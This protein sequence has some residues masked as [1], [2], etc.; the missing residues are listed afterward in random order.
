MN[1]IAI[2]VKNLSKHFG[3]VRAVDGIS[4]EINKAE[5]FGFLGPNGAGKTTTI[6]ILC[7]LLIPTSGEAMV[8]GFNVVT[9]PTE[10]R[11]SIGIIFQ[12]PS[13][14]E[15][16][17]AYENLN[18]HGMIY[19]L[20]SKI[21]KA[22]I[23]EVLNMVGLYPKKDYVVR[24]FSGGMK[25]RL[26]I[27][28]GLMHSPKILFL[29]EPTIGLDPQTRQYIWD[30][31]LNLAQRQSITVFLTTHYMD[32]AEICQRV[33]IIDHGKI[34]DLDTPAVLKNKYNVVSLNEVFLQVTGRDIR[35]EGSDEKERLGQ[36]LRA[37]NKLR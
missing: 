11:K 9:N 15:R 26:E 13:L 3:P 12:D 17:S 8:N 35:E 4:F 30:Y 31:I 20:P 29:D 19:H 36:F 23:E 7:T 28:R 22:R 21:R 16:L 14:D 10:V 5:L 33:G 1:G 2:S 25:R 34:V 6:N 37:R 18:F 32:E 27:A 24:T